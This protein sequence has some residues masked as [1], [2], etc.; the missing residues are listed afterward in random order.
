[1]FCTLTELSTGF[2]DKPVIGTRCLPKLL[3]AAKANS[4]LITSYEPS[5]ISEISVR[6]DV[7][8]PAASDASLRLRAPCFQE[9]EILYGWNTGGFALEPPR[10][11]LAE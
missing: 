5:D 7:E 3:L 6:R 4:E 9:P 11:L 10:L 2:G 1:M 8:T